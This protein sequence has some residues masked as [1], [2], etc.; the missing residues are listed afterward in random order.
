MERDAWLA[1]PHVPR[2]IIPVRLEA[3]SWCHVM[4]R[5]AFRRPNR[6]WRLSCCWAACRVFAS[7]ASKGSSAWRSTA[8]PNETWHFQW[9]AEC[10]GVISACHAP[11]LVRHPRTH[12]PD[13]RAHIPSIFSF[14]QL[15]LAPNPTYAPEIY[16][17]VEHLTMILRMH[18][19]MGRP[20]SK[21]WHFECQTA[22][23][24]LRTNDCTHGHRCSRSMQIPNLSLPPLVQNSP[25]FNVLAAAVIDWRTLSAGHFSMPQHRKILPAW[26]GDWGC[27]SNLEHVL[28]A[29]KSTNTSN[30]YKR[31]DSKIVYTY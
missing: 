27:W 10:H 28:M 23:I 24:E 18:S 4:H 1:V 9:F 25:D 19:L 31:Y 26:E 13:W 17:F 15:F 2:C 22:T 30:P 12:W 8:D 7:S 5:A 11:V 21:K 3:T 16:I 29:T 14:R 20:I 6:S